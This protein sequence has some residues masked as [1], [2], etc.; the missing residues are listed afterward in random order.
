MKQ[1]LSILLVLSLVLPVTGESVEPQT[2]GC[3][4]CGC[5]AMSCCPIDTGNPD[6][7]APANVPTGQ[8]RVSAPDLALQSA[9][10]FLCAL[11]E[12][13]LEPPPGNRW[14]R[15]PNQPIAAHIRNCTFLI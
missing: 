1:V 3:V 4:G 7:D 2:N 15:L 12:T 10:F 14:F 8:Q 5:A 6:K 9:V 11:D 13:G